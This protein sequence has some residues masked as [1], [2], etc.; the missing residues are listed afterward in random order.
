MLKGN[1]SP[2]N[3]LPISF[4]TGTTAAGASFAFSPGN[5]QLSGWSHMIW[6]D[7][8]SAG[9]PEIGYP[10]GYYGRGFKLPL[11]LSSS[12]TKLQFLSGMSALVSLGG[13]AT[14]IRAYPGIGTAVITI[15]G[16]AGGG[17]VKSGVG[18]ATITISATADIL[19][20]LLAEGLATIT[21]SAS[22]DTLEAIGWPTGSATITL[23]GEAEP[24]AIGWM[25]GT[26]DI[27]TTL[28]APAIASEVWNAIASSFNESGT[29]GELLNASGAGGNPWIAEI[30]NNVNAQEAIKIIL[31]ALAGK[32]S[33][34]GTGTITFR[35]VNDTADRITASVDGTGNRTNVELDV[36]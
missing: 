1:Y 22:A 13:T 4:R 24:M 14:G 30:E 18:S 26:T 9:L 35:D 32:V 28:T 8:A 27:Q 11:G 23:T 21:L 33:G 25:E 3:R 12:T 15:T 19:A 29:M 5:Y 31:S 7:G 20:I 17:L 16:S 36:S 10:S 6:Q 34:A 2:F